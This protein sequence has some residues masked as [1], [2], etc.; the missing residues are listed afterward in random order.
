[1]CGVELAVYL[2]GEGIG[3]ARGSEQRGYEDVE[4]EGLQRGTDGGG[5][6]GEANGE[7][8]G[9]ERGG[10]TERAEVVSEQHRN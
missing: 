2:L 7:L 9:E 6:R 1:M 10:R 3:A 8:W 4:C 5:R